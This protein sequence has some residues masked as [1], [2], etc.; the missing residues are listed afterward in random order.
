MPSHAFAVAESL[1]FAEQRGVSTHGLVRLGI[2]LERIAAGGINSKATIR[3][4]RESGAT[5]MVDADNAIGAPAA[6]F[7]AEMCSKKAKKHGCAMVVVSNGNH[8]G[9]AGFYVRNIS[10]KGLI[11]VVG[12]NSDAFMAPP[13]GGSAVLGSNPLAIGLP[14]TKSGTEVLLDM[15]TSATTVG[16]LIVAQQRGDSIPP[17][18]AVDRL[19]RSTT[20]PT[21]GLKGA[22]LPAAG[23]KG[24]G[25]A[26]MI[27]ILA[28]LGGADLSSVA[29]PLYGPREAPQRL[30]FF[31]IG[32]DPDHF[33]GTGVLE[34]VIQNLCVHVKGARDKDHALGCPMIPGEPEQLSEKAVGQSLEFGDP[35]WNQ[36]SKLSEEW[37]VPLP[38]PADTKSEPH[39][40]AMSG[41]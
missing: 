34:T 31:F 40:K 13:G 11:G 3:V 17:G 28:T 15:A 19:G 2:Y 18:W 26:F 41:D 39:G 22:L 16:K 1:I 7:G 38:P 25:L 10:S 32:I 21:E 33:L 35:L 8:F 37:R 5:A 14:R 23:A 29:G 9:A 6:I 30:G 4:V 27:D 20:D 12:C 36:L 24:F